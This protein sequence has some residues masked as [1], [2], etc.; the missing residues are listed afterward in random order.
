MIIDLKRLNVLQQTFDKTFTSFTSLILQ[1]VY[2][3][4]Y[5]VICLLDF[6]NSTTENNFLPALSS[7]LAIYSCSGTVK[8]ITLLTRKSLLTKFLITEV[9]T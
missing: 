7:R 8:A 2:S 4:N 3:Y 5:R 1:V 9:Q 6:Q